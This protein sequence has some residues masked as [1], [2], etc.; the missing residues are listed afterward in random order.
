MFARALDHPPA[1]G[2]AIAAGPDVLAQLPLLQ[3]VA[4]GS[5]I[6]TSYDNRHSGT[7]KPETGAFMASRC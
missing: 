4:F 7:G 1:G 3:F 5:T 6:L 2:L